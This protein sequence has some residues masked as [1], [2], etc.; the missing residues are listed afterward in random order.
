MEGGSFII[1][2]FIKGLDGLKIPLL[3]IIL[4]QTRK[5]WLRSISGWYINV[6]GANI[7]SPNNLTLMSPDIVQN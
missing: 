3:L 6:L 2:F 1:L 7:L 4:L 5:F